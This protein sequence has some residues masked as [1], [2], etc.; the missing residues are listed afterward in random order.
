MSATV[1]GK[2]ITIEGGE[3]SGKSTQLALL[4][5]YLARQQVPVVFTREP[6]G[7]PYAEALRSAVLTSYDQPLSPLCEY[8]TFSAARMDHLE[9][10]IW[11][12]LE[13]GQH[14]ICDRFIDSSLVYQGHVQGLD[15]TLM[16]ASYM[17]WSQGFM[18]D[19]T[20][21]LD[22]DPV[23]ALQR[24]KARGGQTNRFDQADL[25][26]HNKIRQGFLDLAKHSPARIHCINAQD[27]CK[28][29]HAAIVN[30]LT[31]QGI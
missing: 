19:I 29:V 31:Q 2:F 26:V 12:A 16:R 21:L 25:D 8:L 9:K 28:N 1:R 10:L 22:I 30:I 6:G 23:I 4:K 11:P 24:L 13:S 20:L 14:V 5:Q 18:P 27:E 3:G 7:T 17:T 15:I